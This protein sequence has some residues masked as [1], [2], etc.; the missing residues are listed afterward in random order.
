MS[1]E[2]KAIT[3]RSIRS[4]GDRP[5]RERFDQLFNQAF[6]DF[7]DARATQQ[8][9]NRA[10][11]PAVDVKETDDTLSLSFELPG[12]KREDVDIAVE[13]RLLTVR[14]ER[15]LEKEAERESYHRIERSYGSF[16]RTFTLPV[17]VAVDR[18]KATLAEGV[19]RVDLPKL[20]AAEPEYV[21]DADLPE[22]TPQLSAAEPED[23]I[24]VEAEMAAREGAHLPEAATR[25]SAAEPEDVIEADLP[26]AVPQLSAAEPA[27]YIDVDPPEATPRH[28]TALPDRGP[29][30]GLSQLHH[31]KSGRLDASRIADYLDVPLKRLAEGLGAKYTSV[32]KTP[33]ALSLQPALQPIKRSL[34]ILESVLGN[35]PT[36]LAWWNSPHPDLGLR[37]PM[38]LLL[39]GR[40][41]PVAD[42]LEAART[43][44]PS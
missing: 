26:E 1:A 19:L 43:G 30:V 9:G 34:E 21:I 7:Y 32:Q 36:V 4:S 10:W 41:E 2:S 29:A 44:T 17:A 22:A 40:V 28:R 14:G 3:P 18:A 16:T 31:P 6:G 11:V 13:D 15:K 25:L 24:D 38:A 42:M 8:S 20:S 35:R 23:Y 39:Q 33:D 5:L 27:D 37:S 12:V